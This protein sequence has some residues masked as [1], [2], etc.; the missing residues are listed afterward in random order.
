MVT[1]RMYR[2]DDKSFPITITDNTGAAIDITGDTIFFTVKSSETDTDANALIKVDVTSHSDPTAGKTTI[3]ITKTL[4]N[5]TA[6]EYP[7]DIQRL[8]GTS[9]STLVKGTFHLIQDITIRTATG[10]TGV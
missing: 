10:Q 3:P 1:L 2:R 4:S 6:G 8:H 9:I 7:F 5:I